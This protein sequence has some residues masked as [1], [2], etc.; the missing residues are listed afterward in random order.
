MQMADESLK[1]FVPA[2]A[3]FQKQQRA[4]AKELKATQW[5]KNQLGRG[6]CHYCEQNFHPSELTMDHLIPIARGGKSDKSNC[7]TACKACNSKKKH[8]LTVE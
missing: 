3:D 8:H 2:P 5:W 6:K 1:F 7:V 4:K